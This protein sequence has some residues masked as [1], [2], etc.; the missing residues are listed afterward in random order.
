MRLKIPIN[1]LCTVCKSDFLRLRK[2]GNM[3]ICSPCQ[4]KQ[5]IVDWHL[6]NPGAKYATRAAW[7]ERNKEKTIASKMQWSARNK[8]AENAKAAKHRAK[9]RAATPPWADI[10]KIK[11]IYVNCP[12][13]HHVDH[14]VPLCGKHV[15]GLHV[16]N[17]LQYLPALENRMKSNHFEGN[18]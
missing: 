14:I 12:A 2:R 8:G 1:C 7:F 15:S 4:R 5:R 13:G 18:P 3:E 10:N 11:E 17:N 6:K 16:E 9:K